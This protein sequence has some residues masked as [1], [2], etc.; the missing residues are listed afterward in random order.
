MKKFWSLTLA[1]MVFALTLA[2]CK[3]SGGHGCDAYGSV[4]Q[5][6]QSDLAAK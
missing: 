4:D 3:S 6:E 5:V 1:G 2:A